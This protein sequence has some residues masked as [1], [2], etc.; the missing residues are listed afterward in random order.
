MPT[1][2]ELLHPSPKEERG[3][4]RGSTWCRAPIPTL[5]DVKYPGCYKILVLSM[6]KRQS[7]TLAASLSSASLTR[8]RTSCRE[9]RS[10]IWKQH[11]KHPYVN[12]KD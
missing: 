5:W 3:N 8:G 9:G 11:S 1:A 7:C 12:T 2:K 6:H 4:L 10:F